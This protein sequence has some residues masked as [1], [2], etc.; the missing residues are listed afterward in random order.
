MSQY[1]YQFQLLYQV[2]SLSETQTKT[3]QSEGSE[4]YEDCEENDLFEILFVI[5]AHLYSKRL[6]CILIYLSSKLETR[7]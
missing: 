4:G 5:F 7:N 3:F 1:Q 6:I 2:T